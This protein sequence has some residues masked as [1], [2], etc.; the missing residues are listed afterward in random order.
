MDYEIASRKRDWDEPDVMRYLEEEYGLTTESES[1]SD[2]DSEPQS[3]LEPELEPEPEV[4]VLH[5]YFRIF[6]H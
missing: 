2:Y 5:P 1:E 6:T 4:C 3:A